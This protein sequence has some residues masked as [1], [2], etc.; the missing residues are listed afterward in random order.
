MSI[1]IQ[2]PTGFATQLPKNLIAN[3]ANFVLH[4]FLDIFLVPYFSRILGYDVSLLV[5]RSTARHPGTN[6][7]FLGKIISVSIL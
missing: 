6:M 1:T 3:A 5:R 7:L 2:N 4:I